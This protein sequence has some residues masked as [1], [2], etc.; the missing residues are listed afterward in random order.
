MKIPR[1]S[2]KVVIMGP[3]A[4]AGSQP[5]RRARRGMLVPITAALS[6]TASNDRART[7]ANLGPSRTAAIERSK[8]LQIEPFNRE[9]RISLLTL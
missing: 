7:V 9:T 6:I 2:L 3:A 1:I 5:R 4:I 8:R